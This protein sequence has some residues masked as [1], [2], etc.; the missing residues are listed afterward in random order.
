MMARRLWLSSFSPVKSRKTS[1]PTPASEDR[2]LGSSYQQA[3][4]IFKERAER[5][6]GEPSE[7]VGKR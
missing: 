1:A 6:L 7:D 2:D 4:G 5:I 3:A